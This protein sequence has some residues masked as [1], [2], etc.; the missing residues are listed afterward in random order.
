MK[1]AVD[2]LVLL[3]SS[4]TVAG[5]TLP[6]VGAIRWDAW[7]GGA[8]QIGE[9]VQE[10]LSIPE[11]RYRLP[12]FT[13][14]R[15]TANETV[16]FETNG[17]SSTAM[18]QELSYAA[19]Y[20]INFWA[21]VAYSPSSSMFYA[22]R[23]Y[24]QAAAG[25]RNQGVNFALIMDSNELSVLPGD[26]T[27]V[28]GY[29]QQPYYQKTPTGRPLAFT[30]SATAADAPALAQLRNATVAAGLPRPYIVAMGWGT[31][32]TQMAAAK[33]LGADAISQ[34]G[35]VPGNL[36]SHPGTPFTFQENA[37]AEIAHNKACA[38]A[39]AKLVPTVTSGW[40]PRPREAKPPPWSQSFNPACNSSKGEGQCWVQDPTMPELTEQTRAVVGWAASSPAVAEAGAVIIS[41]WNEHDEGHWIC[42]SLRHGP[43]KLRAI[44]QGIQQAASELSEGAVVAGAE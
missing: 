24:L 19:Q 40:D 6:A 7:Y 38:A 1:F 14:E 36:A 15:T 13:Q 27:R 43:E 35:Y 2:H 23:L 39:G 3:L 4:C 17:N 10:Q 44:R 28:V 20:G 41:A 31:V 8:D 12:F 16:Q 9:Y 21:F 30:F 26:L 5:G 32:Q 22:Q 42:P 25:G 11:W 18:A 33:Q 37:A 34:Y 29:F